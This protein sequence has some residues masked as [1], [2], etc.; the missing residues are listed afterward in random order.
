M[1]AAGKG[2]LHAL[3]GAGSRIHSG[4]CL[5][6]GFCGKDSMRACRLSWPGKEPKDAGKEDDLKEADPEPSRVFHIFIL[7]EILSGVNS[8]SFAPCS[9]HRPGRL[10][11]ILSATLGHVPTKYPVATRISHM[12]NIPSGY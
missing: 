7:E 6:A 3:H 11:L 8:G 1:L 10:G 9:G 2:S 12:N 4:P 5:N